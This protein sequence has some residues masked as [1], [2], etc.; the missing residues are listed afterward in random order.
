MNL[1]FIVDLETTGLD[2]N[3]DEIWSIGCMPIIVD[4]ENKKIKKLNLFSELNKNIDPNKLNDALKIRLSFYDVVNNGNAISE[5]DLLEKFYMFIGSLVLEHNAKN[6]FLIGYN[7]NFDK[8]FI[9]SRGKLYSLSF[10]DIFK[11]QGIDIMQ[12]Y[13]MYSMTNKSELNEYFSLKNAITKLCNE[14]Y[15]FHTS[16]DDVLATYKLLCILLNK[17]GNFEEEK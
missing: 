12:W 14:T 5:K 15:K 1:Y 6:S 4:R 17:Y 7:V 16:S 11:P 9:Y 8:E 13:I 10:G 2:A 3:K